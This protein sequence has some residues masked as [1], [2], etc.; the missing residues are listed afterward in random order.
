MELGGVGRPAWWWPLVGADRAATAAKLSLPIQKLVLLFGLGMS[1]ASV[2]PARAIAMLEVV[3]EAIS[4]ELVD[5][6]FL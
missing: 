1:T 6:V 4:S 5:Q 3:V 2:M